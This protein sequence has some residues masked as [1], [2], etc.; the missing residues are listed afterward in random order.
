MEPIRTI[1]VVT[2][3]VAQQSPALAKAR[4]LANAFR[5]KV[6]LLLCDINP[7]LQ[8]NFYP[9]VESYESVVEPARA[10]HTARL[11]A[12][13]APFLADKLDVTCHVEFGKPL[14][15]VVVDRIALRQP[16]L[17][18]KDTHHHSLIRRTLLTNTDWH[19]IRDCPSPLLL[20]KDTE[21]ATGTR[22]AAAV[23]PG[24]PHD[25]PAALDHAVVYAA[26]RFARAFATQPSLVHCWSPVALY[27]LGAAG[28]GMGGVPVMMPPEVIDSQRAL[29]RDKLEHLARVHDVSQERTFLR[30]GIAVEELPK[31]AAEH[32]VD[33]LV[34]GAVSRSG[35]DRIFIGHTAEML[36][37]NLPCDVL[38]IKLSAADRAIGKS[39]G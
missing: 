15:H 2:D 30:E 26:D 8:P 24:H 28:G 5:A 14:H 6:E 34:M 20:V 13:A 22:F 31:F 29:D 27:A 35:L 3:P 23:D 9:D 39:V 4:R 37:E 21:W 16:D 11:K 7:A 19:L 1:L 38:V 17:V 33:V 12:L 32:A 36:L 25:T 18:I 10:T